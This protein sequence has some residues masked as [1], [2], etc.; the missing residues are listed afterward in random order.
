M[1]FFYRALVCS[2]FLGHIKSVSHTAFTEKQSTFT[3]NYIELAYL[4][5]CS[6][7]ITPTFGV[8]KKR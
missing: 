3:E 1:L 8:Y 2:Y 7:V 5:W 4:L 6:S